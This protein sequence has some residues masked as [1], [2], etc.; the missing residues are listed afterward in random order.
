MSTTMTAQQLAK[1]TGATLERASAF[2]PHITDGMDYYAINTAVRQAAFLA[3]IG[4]E[5]G[6]LR[7]TREIWGPTPQQ[8]RYEGRADLGNTQLGDGARYRGRG[9]IQIT[10]R[11]N[12]SAASA[13]LGVDLIAA[14]ELLE[15][16]ALAVRSAAWWW[17]RHGCNEIADT[18]DFARLTRRINGGLNGLTDR[19]ARWEGAQEVLA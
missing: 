9:L 15:T 2:L 5:S 13:G 17:A 10:G 3:Q 12:Y 14:P 7:Y 19:L 4:H 16:P 6:G 11:S 8:Q 1:A 18:G